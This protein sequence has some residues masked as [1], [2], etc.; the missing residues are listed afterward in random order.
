MQ[1]V[2][3]TKLYIENFKKKKN[4][5]YYNRWGKCLIS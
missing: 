2:K 4:E 5:I 1:L 3:W